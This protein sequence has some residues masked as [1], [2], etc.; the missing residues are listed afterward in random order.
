MKADLTNVLRRD[1]GWTAKK[2]VGVYFVKRKNFIP[3]C[4][5]LVQDKHIK[6]EVFN[7][8]SGTEF[9]T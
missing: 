5:P 8:V 3:I 4:F 1:S 2:V 9:C 6:I 7:L